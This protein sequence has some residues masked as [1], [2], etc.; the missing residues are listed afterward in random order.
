V[1]VTADRHEYERAESAR[2]GEWRGGIDG[3]PLRIRLRAAR[4]RRKVSQ[5]QVGELFGV[6]Q[7]TVSHWE[8]GA[9]AGGKPIPPDK[10]EAVTRWVEAD[11]VAS[12]GFTVDGAAETGPGSCPGPTRDITSG[13]PRRGGL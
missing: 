5:K 10:V 4:Q 13:S 11:E 3:Q 9:E 6:S 7:V 2:T 12:G 1:R 8:K